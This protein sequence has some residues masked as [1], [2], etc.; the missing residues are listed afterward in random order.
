[1]Y[2]YHVFFVAFVVAFVLFVAI[3]I[4]FAL[5]VAVDAASRKMSPLWWTIGTVLAVP[6]VLPVYLARRDLRAGET[7]KG[8]RGW[9]ALKYF[10]LFWT[11]LMA[12][13]V[14]ACT[15]WSAVDSAGPAYDGE[16]PGFAALLVLI[17]LTPVWFLPT[18]AAVVLGAIL[19]KPSVVERGP[20]GRMA[21][22]GEGNLSGPGPAG[23][24]AC[25][26]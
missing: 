9:N 4:I 21:G 2:G 22:M 1:M 24:A 20:T 19:R 23:S 16:W 26:P 3:A 6:V 11:L 7:R 5:F 8:G 12:V 18:V 13:A 17:A 25:R 15:L 10:A 14:V